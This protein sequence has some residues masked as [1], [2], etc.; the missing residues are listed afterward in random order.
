MI[1]LDRFLAETSGWDF[2]LRLA[3]TTWALEE[4]RQFSDPAL[5]LPQPVHAR[6]IVPTVR[7]WLDIAPT[8]AAPHLWLGLLMCDDPARHLERALEL[9]ASCE[10][11]RQSLSQWILADIDYNQHH[12]PE[13]YLNDPRDDL[14]ALDVAARLTD[15]SSVERWSNEARQEIAELRARAED[16]IGKRP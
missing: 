3:F 16:W 13:Y 7:E 8:E 15:G 9:D 2:A 4:S 12:L 11:A 1:Q 14:N 10:P 5:L 6:L